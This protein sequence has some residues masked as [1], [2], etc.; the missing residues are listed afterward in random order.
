MKWFQIPSETNPSKKYYLKESHL[1]LHFRKHWV[2][3]VKFEYG[4][5]GKTNIINRSGFWKDFLIK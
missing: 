3:L 5:N 1:Y 4:T 2:S